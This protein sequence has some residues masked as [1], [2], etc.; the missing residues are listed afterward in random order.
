MKLLR[1]LSLLGL[2]TLLAATT[3]A[4]QYPSKPIRMV[5]PFPAGGPTDSAARIVGQALGKTLGQPVVVENRPGADGAIAAQAVASAVP[6]GYTVLFTSSS[7]VALAITARPAPFEIAD[8]APVAGIGR[9]AFG[10][11]TNLEVPSASVK[12]FVTYVRANPG[13][14]NYPTANVSEHLAALRFM[15]ATGVDMVRVPYKGAAQLMPDLMA[16]RVQVYFGPV[17][18]GLPHVRAGRLRL[19][20]T[21]TP[22]RTAL[23]PD[24][25]TAAEAGIPGLAVPSLQM[26]LAPA[27]TPRAAIE[28]LAAE[29]KRVVDDP[30]V[31]SQLEKLALVVDVSTMDELAAAMRETHETWAQYARDNGG[32][33]K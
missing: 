20:A 11:Y 33:A 32:E 7:V 27:K 12:E 5:V 16:G 19:L 4:A 13:K 24:V 30:E 23:T 9:F 14:L 18:G 25:P 26:I 1:N 2:A 10:M 21:L 29:V 17:G 15:K 3:A 28:R 22:T 31:R 6:D 8:F